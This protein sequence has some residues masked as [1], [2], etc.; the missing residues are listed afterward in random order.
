MLEQAIAK[1]LLD[2]DAV[3]LRPDNPF[4]Y[5]SGLLSPIYCDNR[6]IMSFPDIR[7]QVIDAFI[8][9]IQDRNL[10]FD[11]VAGCATAGITHA[12][13]IADRLNLPM[14][15]VRSSAKA[16]GKGNQIE[17][18]IKPGQTVLI[19]ED[20][21]STGKSAI[22]V[23]EALRSNGATVHDC[24]A[25]FSYELPIAKK[26]FTDAHVR[27]ITLSNFNALL[28]TARALDLLNNQ[29]CQLVASWNKDP[30]NWGQ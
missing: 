9:T 27:A 21:I 8:Q 22:A 11:V 3:Q 6:L 17:G 20:L 30:D 23:A 26:Q 24:L 13:W 16:H 2:I 19:V 14:I 7:K 25:V 1:L 10:E 28:T 12:A 4:Q 18:V 5:T 15:Y 29:Q